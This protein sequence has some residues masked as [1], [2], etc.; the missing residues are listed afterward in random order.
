MNL[1]AVVFALGLASAV[2]GADME[3]EARAI[4][5]ML[6]APC[7]FTQV[8]AIHQSAAAAEV[9]RDVR[10]RLAAGETRQQILDAY[11]AQYG[12]RVLAE[13]PATGFNVTLYV[14]P[15]LMLLASAVLV[16]AV[17]RRFTYRP[18]F[19]AEYSPETA[20]VTD[21]ARLDDELRD[22]D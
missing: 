22:L 19:V 16:A 14:L 13:P 6:I 20:S 3:R 21:Q 2:P 4:E 11:V 12:N 10:V 18:A 8:V 1:V 5:H 7:C 15:V 17:V 9:R